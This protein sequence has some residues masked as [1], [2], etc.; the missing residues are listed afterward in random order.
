MTWWP[1]QWNK[2]KRLMRILYVQLPTNMVVMM[3]KA[4]QEFV[5]SIRLRIREWLIFIQSLCFKDWTRGKI[6]W[7]FHQNSCQMP[8][9][10]QRSVFMKVKVCIKFLSLSVSQENVEE[11]S[12]WGLIRPLFFSIYCRVWKQQINCGHTTEI[13][14]ETVD[15]YI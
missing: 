2:P 1:C 3:W 9:H 6:E 11:Q 13:G 7:R 8:Q 4:N 10:R 15:T 14:H 12:N 5:H